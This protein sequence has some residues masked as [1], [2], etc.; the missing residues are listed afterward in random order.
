MLGACVNARSVQIND[1]F[2]EDSTRPCSRRCSAFKRGEDAKVRPAGRPPDVG[3]EGGPTTLI[4]ATLRSE[5]G[6]A[7]DKDRIFT[8][9][10]GA[11]TGA[12]RLPCGGGSWDG[13]RRSS[14]AARTPSS[15]R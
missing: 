6:D 9:L 12:C 10:Y 8:N 14:T 3:A 13:T 15:M 11:T 2:Y 4:P 7:C 1:D 5:V